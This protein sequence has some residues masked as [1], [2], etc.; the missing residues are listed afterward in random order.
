MSDQKMEEDAPVTLDAMVAAARAAPIAAKDTVKLVTQSGVTYTTTRRIVQQSA[1]ITSMLEDDK[2]DDEIPEIPLLDM[3]DQTMKLVM[4]FL[5]HHAEDPAKEIEKPIKT[6]KLDEIVSKW[7]A[8]FISPHEIPVLFDI[9]KASN[10][11]DIPPLL[12]LGIC[13]VATMVKGKEP[14]QVKEM[15]NI[16]PDITPEEEKKV[17][18]DNPWIFD[19][20]NPAPKATPATTTTAATDEEE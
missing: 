2:D 13:R 7:D 4:S 9:I 18:D 8:D 3:T 6:N 20:S 16:S 11:L 17:R 1:L 19:V 12:D 5:E 15:F 10:Y 14:E